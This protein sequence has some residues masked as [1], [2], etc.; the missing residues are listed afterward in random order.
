MTNGNGFQGHGRT[1]SP[2]EHG[3][4]GTPD[5][6]HG[7]TDSPS[8]NGHVRLSTEGLP[9]WLAPVVRAAQTVKPTQLSRFLPP[10]S[11]A[12]RQSAVLILFGEG[13][14]GPELLLMERSGSLRS[15]SRPAFLPG[16]LPR[17]RGRRS[18][19]GRPPEGRPARGRGGDRARPP[20][21][22]AL[23]RAAPPLH[24]GERFRRHARTGMVAFTQSRRRGRSGRDG[25]R[26]HGP[27]GRSHGSRQPRDGRPPAR[28]RRPCL[29][30]RI[31]SGLGFYGR[32]DRQDPA[33]RGLGAPLGPYEA[34]PARL[35]RM[36]RLRG[37]GDRDA[38]RGLNR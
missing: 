14:E 9:A 18:A 19:D 34:G 29:P 16:R 5:D 23:R 32:G 27:R 22:P 4:T 37:R 11:G 36:T 10:E 33:L 8:P 25:P 15:H 3:H 31:R 2:N 28:P 12:G 6:E 13:A 38:R 24:P 30:R 17:P 20:G 7:R 35:A 21:R 1:D 26:L